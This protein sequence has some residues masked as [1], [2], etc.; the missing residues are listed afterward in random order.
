M[1]HLVNYFRMSKE[2]QIEAHVAEIMKILGLDVDNPAIKDTPKRVAK[3]YVEELF[4]G[5]HTEPPKITTFPNEGYDQMVM[6]R[7]IQFYSV[8]EHHLVPIV[9]KATV[10]YL[11]QEKVIGLSKINRVVNH[12]AAKPQLQERLT[13]EIAKFLEEKLDTENVAVVISAEHYCC[14]MRGVRDS[15]SDTVT[16]YFGGAFR[17]QEL[18]AEFLNLSKK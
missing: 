6:V 10:A 9:G 13:T 18:R 7:D 8:C 3:M 17:S 15:S 5:L 11:P 1:L 2:K 16:S 12:F 4:V 14:K